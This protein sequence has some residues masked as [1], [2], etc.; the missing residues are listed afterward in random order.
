MFTCEKTYADIPFAHRQHRH[1]GHCAFIHGH[2]WSFTF[3]FGCREL[4]E[5]GFVVDF[6]KLKELKAW[7]DNTFDHACLFNKDDP[8]A[9]QLAD[10]LAQDGRALFKPYLVEQCSSEGIAKHIFEKADALI[11]RM[12]DGRAFV[13]RTLVTEDSR[14]SATYQPPPNRE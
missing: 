7:I 10:M 4:D 1:D 6:G 13:V 3:T 2:N 12:S 5:C 8:M 14:N 9:Q 11:K